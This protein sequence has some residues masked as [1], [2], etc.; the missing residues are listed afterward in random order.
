MNIYSL[1]LRY[2]EPM[3]WVLSAIPLVIGLTW[4]GTSM[5]FA[6]V[7]GTPPSAPSQSPMDGTI[8]VVGTSLSAAGAFYWLISFLQ[9]TI[10]RHDA[11]KKEIREVF[12]KEKEELMDH[13]EAL[14]IKQGEQHAAEVAHLR[15]ENKEWR[16][17]YN[18]ATK[19]SI[20][21]ARSIRMA[22]LTPGHPK[23]P[24]T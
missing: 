22:Q 21:D 12:L 5:A 10:A 13:Y 14:M 4:L 1:N 3:K 6:Q 2:P 19:D 17:Q 24:S 11:E 7:D 18:A 16:D 8:P 23:P 20:Q 9:S 15:S